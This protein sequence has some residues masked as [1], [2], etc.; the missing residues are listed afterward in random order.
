MTRHLRGVGQTNDQQ[1]ADEAINEAATIV[2]QETQGEADVIPLPVAP[3]PPLPKLSIPLQSHLVAL[4]W[5]TLIGGA[6]GWLANRAATGFY[7]GALA[8]AGF[9]AGEAALYG[10]GVIDNQ[11]RMVYG[12][13]G[14]ATLGGAGYL[15]YRG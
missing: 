10:G 12:A 14:V 3:P 2:D 9:A 5:P 11:T 13:L 1:A 15:S 7:I 4:F 6:V 8:G